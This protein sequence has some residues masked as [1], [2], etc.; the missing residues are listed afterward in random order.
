MALKGREDEHGGLLTRAAPF[1]AGEFTQAVGGLGGDGDRDRVH[2][3]RS[4]GHR[5]GDE[6]GS[7]PASY[8]ASYSSVD[9]DETPE[10]SSAGGPGFVRRTGG[11][12]YRLMSLRK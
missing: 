12:P 8:L 1:A 7:K 11:S 10:V 5:V 9:R 6:T 3:H 2:H 4:V